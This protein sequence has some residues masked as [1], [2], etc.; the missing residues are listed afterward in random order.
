MD[1][2]DKINEYFNRLKQTLDLVS[3]KDISQ[4]MKILV[5]AKDEDKNIF[6][7]GNGGSASTASHFCCD[8]NKGISFGQEKMFKFICLNDNIPTMMAYANDLGYEEIF[9]GPLKN[10]LQKGDLVIGVSG[11]GNSMNVV[12]ALEYANSIG[13]FTIGLTGYSGGKVKKICKHNVHIPIDDM[14]ITE[15]L[16]LVLDHCMMSIL[17]EKS[18]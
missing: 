11:S 4:L 16:H 1:Y 5:K 12:K 15:D 2:T 17:C 6:I 18:I 10:F 14:Q 3:K 8:F 13:A 9:I 7:M